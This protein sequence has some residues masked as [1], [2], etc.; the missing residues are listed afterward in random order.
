MFS[1]EYKLK[2]VDAD[3]PAI[4]VPSYSVETYFAFSPEQAKKMHVK[5]CIQPE[6]PDHHHAY[7]VMHS[8]QES[9]YESK[10]RW[11]I[12]T[13][14]KIKKERM[15]ELAQLLDLDKYGYPYKEVIDMI[16]GDYFW[17]ISYDD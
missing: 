3:K 4:I 13:E 9:F 8:L 14:W 17:V 15:E 1:R 16:E 12:E 2:V 7:H 5:Q 6:L 11:G 10:E